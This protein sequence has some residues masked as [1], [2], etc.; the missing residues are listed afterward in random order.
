M[1]FKFQAN[2][3]SPSIAAAFLWLLCENFQNRLFI[4]HHWLSPPVLDFVTIN[5][6]YNYW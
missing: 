4:E 5:I 1:D 6:T 3:K 2:E